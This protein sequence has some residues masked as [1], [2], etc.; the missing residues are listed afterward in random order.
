MEYEISTGRKQCIKCNETVPKGQ[1]GFLYAS[2]AY[3]NTIHY[4]IMCV[5]CQLKLIIEA[6]GK[7]YIKKKYVNEY[8]ATLV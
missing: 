4:R 3:K 6:T 5:K 2:T 7:K 1:V 8:V